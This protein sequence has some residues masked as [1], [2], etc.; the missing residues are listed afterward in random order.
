MLFK[1]G[2]LSEVIWVKVFRKDWLC[3]IIMRIKKIMFC[4]QSSCFI[5][6]HSHQINMSHPHSI[7]LSCT[8]KHSKYGIIQ[9]AIDCGKTIIKE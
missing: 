5:L 8:G 9:E 3:C 6:S 7:Y 1:W 4:L 2:Y